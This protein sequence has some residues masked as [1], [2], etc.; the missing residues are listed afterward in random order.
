[1][2]SIFKYIKKILL[3]SNLKIKLLFLFFLTIFSSALDILNLVLIVPIINLIFDTGSNTYLNNNFLSLISKNVTNKNIILIFGFVYFLKTLITVFTYRYIVKIKYSLQ[4]K[5]KLDLITKYQKLDYRTFINKQSS[6]YIHNI[7]GLVIQYSNGLFCL[8]RLFSEITIVS[9]I[10]FY[11]IVFNNVR[12]F[13]IFVIFVIIL[14]LY[15][16]L[17]KKKILH[18]SK[19]IRSYNVDIIQIVKDAISGI[20]EIKVIKKEFFFNNILMHRAKN[21]AKNQTV[22]EVI[23]FLPRHALEFVFLSIFLFFLFFNLQNINS[24]NIYFAQIAATLLYAFL[25]I[26]PSISAI[27]KEVSILNNTVIATNILYEDLFISK[28][29]VLKNNNL[30]KKTRIEEWNFDSL[31]F[32][33]IS[34]MY[35]KDNL[36][37]DNVNFKINKNT[38]T[39]LI[40]ESGSG[41]TTIVDLIFQFYSPTS[42]NIYLNNHLNIG[43]TPLMNHSF[44]LSQNRFLFNDTIFSNVVISEDIKTY[45]EFSQIQKN[46]F[47]RA[48][49]ITRLDNLINKKREGL[50][51][52]IGEAGINLSGGQRQR[53]SLARML[54]QD[55]QFNILD[56]ATSEIDTFLEEKIIRELISLSS[57]NKTFLII[58]HNQKLD[59]IIDNTLLLK[60]KKIINYKK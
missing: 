23:L 24:N 32:D 56:E 36:I 41:K 42:G 8:L 14:F 45:Q 30:K 19:K 53:L 29:D 26:M 12:I 52:R 21:L 31:V 59:S 37:L 15:H 55:K 57:Q 6:Y 27:S 25:R 60:N 46:K 48:I 33:N 47:D 34:F 13:E 38:S 28:Q 40:G 22:Y 51:Y 39:I 35:D 7:T 50:Q 2:S 4:A 49:E 43:D 18:I 17:L 1:M 20:K 16:I 9:S 11:L 44:Y 58:S 3:I 5:L 54:Y 10:L